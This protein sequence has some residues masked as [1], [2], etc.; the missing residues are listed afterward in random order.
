MLQR[1]KTTSSIRSE[2]RSR[3]LVFKTLVRTAGITTSIVSRPIFKWLFASQ[4]SVKVSVE[5]LVSSLLL[6]TAQSSIGSNL[7][8]IKALRN[9][10]ASFLKEVDFIPGVLR[11]NVIDFMPYSFERVNKASEEMLLKEH[12]YV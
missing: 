5:E 8:K 4:L 6:L 10:A 12:R 2:Q 9:V 7:G 1:I 3:A 11:E